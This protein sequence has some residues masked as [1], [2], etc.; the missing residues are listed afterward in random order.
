MLIH[1]TIL[2]S[3]NE[4]AF[5]T[6]LLYEMVLVT[7][8]WC[9]SRVCRVLLIS[10]EPSVQLY[11][12]PT[13]EDCLIPDLGIFG[14]TSEISSDCLAL[15]AII[16]DARI[17]IFTGFGVI[18]CLIRGWFLSACEQAEMSPFLNYRTN[19]EP[20]FSIIHFHTGRQHLGR[21]LCDTYIRVSKGLTGKHTNLF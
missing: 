2:T 20:V 5:V 18:I 17:M 7:T 9:D 8:V 16:A 13:C 21:N 10:P 19:D 11:S 6:I 4:F 14:H 3:T 1:F 12:S 15:G